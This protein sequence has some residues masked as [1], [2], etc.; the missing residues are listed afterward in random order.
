M[1]TKQSLTTH[2]IELPLLWISLAFVLGIVAAAGLALAP[3]NLWLALGSLA[4][5]VMIVGWRKLDRLA[6]L[7]ALASL[8]L[9][10]GALRY[11][12]AQPVVSADTLIYYNETESS[13]TIWGTLSRPPVYRYTYIELW[14]DVEQI[15]LGEGQQSISGQ[16]LARTSLGERWAYGDYV[17]LTGRLRTPGDTA[18]DSYRL[19]L[20]RQG[21]HSLMPFA[22]AQRLAAGGGG[23]LQAA[24]H[25]FRARGVDELHRLYPDPVASLLAGIL[26]GDES[27]ISQTLKEDFNDTA[28]RHI[29][30]ISGFNISIIAGL[31]LAFFAR[32]FGK[33]K[34][35]WLAAV[36]IVVY[37]LLVGAQ[38]S[39]MR[40]AIM[41]LVVLGSQVTGREQHSLNTLAFTAALMALIN[42]LVLWDVGF[43]LSFS[44]T[45]GLLIYAQPLQAWASAQLEQRLPAAWAAR[46]KGPLYEYVLLTLAAQLLTLPLLLHH[47]GRLS[48]V[49][50]PANI[51]ILPL[52]PAILIFGGLSL[53]AGLVIPVLGQLLALVAWPL[54]LL[55]IRIVEWLA[56]P[57]WAAYQVGVFSMAMVLAYYAAVLAASLAPVRNAVRSLQLRPALPAVALAAVAFGAWGLVF[58]APSGRLA[59]T[60]LNVPG[61]ALL[62]RTPTG[63]NLL[64]NGGASAVELSSQLGQH[65]PP[66]ARQLDWLLVLGERAQQTNGLQSGVEHLHI[67]QVA[68]AHQWPPAAFTQLLTNLEAAGMTTHELAAGQVMDLGE[69]AQLQVVGIGPRG[70]TVLISWHNFQALLPLGL[71]ADQLA[72]FEQQSIQGID[73]ILLADGGYAPLNPAGWLAALDAQTYWLANDGQMQHEQLTALQGRTLLQTSELGWLRAETDGYTLWLSA[74]RSAEFAPLTQ[75]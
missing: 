42:P 37:T 61:E 48:L 29:V 4:V 59:I 18:D 71:D 43:Q 8:L 28:T 38:A 39:V 27:G 74:E 40:A 46:I 55:T 2:L 63:R 62:V 25:T 3:T 23:G 41:G 15:D 54:A 26:L 5:L 45:L 64:I 35:L 53:L 72:Q 12:A 67:A 17:K 14:V 73:I 65:L 69:G 19:Y 47:F 10:V 51:L 52:Q 75:P 50:L 34:G 44:A 31:A 30:A 24:L 22:S 21:V 11:Q 68:W 66:F 32:W 70:A 36:C 16:M 13:V 56:S 49:A 9:C 20:A 58:S 33:R 1:D 60:L 6:R 57:S 7:G